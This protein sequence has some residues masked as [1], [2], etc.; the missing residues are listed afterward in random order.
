M[1]RNA[2]FQ[3]GCKRVIE[4]AAGNC[5]GSDCFSGL[6]VHESVNRDIITKTTKG[7]QLCRLIYYSFSALHFLAMSS[8]IIRST[9]LYL[10]QLVIFTNVPAGLKPAAT[11]MNINRCCKYNQV[12]LM[13]G[14]NIA[15]KT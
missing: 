11:L 14:E 10:Q 1:K 3:T 13:M 6:D 4:K 12:L 8:P 5:N 15:R 7:T 9:Y 2:T